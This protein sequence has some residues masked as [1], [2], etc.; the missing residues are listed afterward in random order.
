M[1]NVCNT[2]GPILNFLNKKLLYKF[3]KPFNIIYDLKG[4]SQENDFEI[5]TLNYTNTL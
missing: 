5:I 2:A 1:K 3:P 4:H